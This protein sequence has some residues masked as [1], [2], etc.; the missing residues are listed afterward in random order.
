[1]DHINNLLRK[2][3]PSNQRVAVDSTPKLHGI[4]DTINATAAA[5][6]PNLRLPPEF[7]DQK[8]YASMNR[9][10][11]EEEYSG[12]AENQ[13]Y[14]RLGIGPILGEIAQRLVRKSDG[15]RIGDDGRPH[16]G[17]D[18]NTRDSPALALY[19]CHD[20]TLAAMLTA[21]GVWGSGQGDWPPYTSSL[22]IELF[23]AQ[24]EP[25]GGATAPSAHYVRLRYN[26]SP[27]R[28][29]ACDAPGHHLSGSKD[30]CTLVCHSGSVCT[31]GLI[32]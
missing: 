14:R 27:V 11:V 7:Y 23:R 13:E 19:G 9:I 10:L 6:D 17:T 18:A 3:M 24:Q 32:D 16:V 2:W 20:S 31:T 12:Y 22:A 26:D 25:G 5:P 4:F 21:L 15:L 8:A 1:M 30:F 29:P 28:L